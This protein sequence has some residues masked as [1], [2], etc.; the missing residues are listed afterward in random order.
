MKPTH[1]VHAVRTIPAP[2]QA[3]WD[4]ISNHAET[5]TWILAARVRLLSPGEPSPNGVGA[6]REVSFPDRALWSTIKERVTAFQAPSTFSYTIIAGMPG[7][8]DHLG[9]LT[10]EPIDADQSTLTWHVDF[11]FSRRHPMGWIAGPFTR[12]FGG[13]LDAALDELVR[14]MRKT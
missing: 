2:A 7:I 14:Q 10:V 6:I 8:R 12:T 9:T 4:R 11:E 13:V 3:V 5:H 1:S